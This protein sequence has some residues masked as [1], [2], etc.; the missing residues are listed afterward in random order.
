MNSEVTWVLAS[1]GNQIVLD[2]QSRLT[3]KVSFRFLRLSI[4][5]TMINP[6][7]FTS[8]DSFTTFESINKLYCRHLVLIRIINWN[9]LRF[10]F[11]ELIL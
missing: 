3:F 5:T 2:S 6:S 7:M 4:V 8:G 9:F 1:S 11:K 10:A